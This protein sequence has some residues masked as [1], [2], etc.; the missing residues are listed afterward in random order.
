MEKPVFC[1]EFT[2]EALGGAKRGC[3]RAASPWK[4]YE[5]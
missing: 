1:D 4:G 5:E 2:N 3:L